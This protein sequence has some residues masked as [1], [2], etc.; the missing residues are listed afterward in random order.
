MQKLQ[1]MMSNVSILTWERWINPE[2]CTPKKED[3]SSLFEGKTVV[4]EHTIAHY[5]EVLQK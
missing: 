1:K 2:S 3:N 4:W 5:I